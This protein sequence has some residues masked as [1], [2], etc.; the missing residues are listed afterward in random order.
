MANVHYTFANRRNFTGCIGE[1]LEG[2]LTKVQWTFTINESPIGEV[3]IS[4]FRLS[5]LERK[6][7]HYRNMIKS[8][9]EH[10]M[11]LVVT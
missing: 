10:C 9:E 2:V 4:L 11:V 7:V 5:Y 3:P 8:S 1:S 6:I